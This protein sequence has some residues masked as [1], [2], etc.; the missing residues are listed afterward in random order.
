[1]ESIQL[2]TLWLYYSMTFVGIGLITRVGE[3]L[4]DEAGLCRD[5]AGSSF[6]VHGVLLVRLG[7][8]F[9]IVDNLHPVDDIIVVVLYI[10]RVLSTS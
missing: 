10:C 2:F 8:V 4:A 5:I 7:R 9:R 3:F 1:M 6:D